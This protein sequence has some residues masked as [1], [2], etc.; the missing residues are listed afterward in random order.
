VFR[1]LVVTGRK[2]SALF[3]ARVPGALA[4]FLPMLA[5]GFAVAIGGAFL[6]AG[7]LPHPTGSNVAK[8]I[9]YAVATTVIDVIIAVG[10]AAF[11]SARVV[12]GV[13]IAWNAIVSHLLMAIGS[14]GAVRKGVDVAAAEQFAP[15][16]AVDPQVHMSKVTAVIVLLVWAAVFVRAGRWWTNRIDA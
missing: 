7:N 3:N 11:A 14:L 6:L 2:R 15:R 12:V 16:H 1:D 9:E 4:V 8:Y 5:I 13:L 10:L